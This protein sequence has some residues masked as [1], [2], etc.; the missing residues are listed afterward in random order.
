M[1][2]IDRIN[3][4]ASA[5]LGFLLQPWVLV[6]AGVATITQAKLSSATE[7]LAVFGFC[8]LSTASYLTLEIYA[9]LRPDTVQS[10][11]NAL[12]EWINTHTDQ[13]IV[14]LSLG[15]GLYLVGESL[16]A[17]VQAG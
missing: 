10:R 11:L 4:L 3:P 13:V 5:G 9:A 8:I 12:L 6:A 16:A 15:I 17:L 14:L 1:T 7:Y 2:G